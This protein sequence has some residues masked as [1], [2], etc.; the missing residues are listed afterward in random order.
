M[1]EKPTLIILRIFT[2]LNLFLGNML[3]FSNIE[4]TNETKFYTM[5]VLYSVF[6]NITLSPMH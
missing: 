5:D 2:F 3:N 1:L 4:V 6:H